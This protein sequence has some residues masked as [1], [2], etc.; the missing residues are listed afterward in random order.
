MDETTILALS[1]EEL[2]RIFIAKI[3]DLK[4]EHIITDKDIE[5]VRYGYNIKFSLSK[6]FKFKDSHEWGIFRIKPKTNTIRA[7]SHGYVNIDKFNEELEERQSKMLNALLDYYS[8]E[9]DIIGE[10]KG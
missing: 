9:D 10:D 7:D 3:R 1:I 6:Y 8:E 2:Y 5:N 4:D